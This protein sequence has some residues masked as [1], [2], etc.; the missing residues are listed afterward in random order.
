MPPG[1]PARGQRPQTAGQGQRSQPSARK[2]AAKASAPASAGV[3]PAAEEQRY[4]FPWTV[5]RQ[6]AYR[7][8]RA[9]AY[10]S[11]LAVAAAP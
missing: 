6:R 4:F 8:S 3:G 1:Q 11:G 5:S 2:L 7:A 9:L 10:S